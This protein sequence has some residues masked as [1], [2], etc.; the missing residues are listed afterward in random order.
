MGP[1]G[2]CTANTPL[3]DSSLVAKAA[4]ETVASDPVLAAATTAAAAAVADEV[5]A[6]AAAVP[7]VSGTWAVSVSEDDDT[8]T[9]ASAAAILF[10]P[11]PVLYLESHANDATGVRPT[12]LHLSRTSKLCGREGQSQGPLGIVVHGLLRQAGGAVPS[13]GS[14]GSSFSP[15][16]LCAS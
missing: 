6:V 10:Q 16:P 14:N 5:A 1:L 3:R 8:T 15:V 13:Q 12:P 2:L 11:R 4:L 7:A 9:A